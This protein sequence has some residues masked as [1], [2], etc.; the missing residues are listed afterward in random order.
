[1]ASTVFEIDNF[2]CLIVSSSLFFAVLMLMLMLSTELDLEDKKA[3]SVFT[4]SLDREIVPPS[5]TKK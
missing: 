2:F 1:V 5:L 3:K 4:Q